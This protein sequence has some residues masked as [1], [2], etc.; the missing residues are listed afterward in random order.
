[1]QG[2]VVLHD[3]SDE[4]DYVPSPSQVSSSEDDDIANF[5]APAPK[6][7]KFKQMTFQRFH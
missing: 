5:A 4:S 2:K 6:Y 3:S 7:T 1:M